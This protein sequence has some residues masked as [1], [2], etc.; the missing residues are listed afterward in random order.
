MFCADPQILVRNWLIPQ[1]L[2]FYVRKKKN[3][4]YDLANSGATTI[5]R[6]CS[7]IMMCLK[8]G[9]ENNSKRR[10]VDT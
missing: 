1:R 10:K 3:C 5:C 2:G 7:K 6:K 8:N 4:W 9:N